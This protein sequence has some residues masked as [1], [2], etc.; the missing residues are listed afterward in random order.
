MSRS[1]VTAG[2]PYALTPTP[3][4]TQKRTPKSWRIARKLSSRPLRSTVTAFQNSNAS[5]SPQLTDL[6]SVLRHAAAVGCTSLLYLH[7]GLGHCRIGPAFGNFST[8]YAPPQS[9]HFSGIGLFHA[10][11]SQSG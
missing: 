9:G 10:T 3:S 2:S 1:R 4:I 5:I 6:K 8:R 11:N 7:S